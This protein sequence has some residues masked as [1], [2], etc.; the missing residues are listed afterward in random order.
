MAEVVPPYKEQQQL[1]IYRD[2]FTDAQRRRV[3]ALVL[4]RYLFPNAL[5]GASQVEVAQWVA[6]GRWATT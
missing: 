3:E 1:G 4:A 2:K 6:T 5:V